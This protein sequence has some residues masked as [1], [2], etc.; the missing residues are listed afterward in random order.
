ML[1]KEGTIQLEQVQVLDQLKRYMDHLN[2]LRRINEGDDTSDS[3]GY[4]LSLV[5]IP[6]SINPGRNSQEG[7][8]AE[9]PMTATP[10]SAPTS[11]L[12]PPRLRHQRCHRPTSHPTRPVPESRPREQSEGVALHGSSVSRAHYDRAQR[13]LRKYRGRFSILRT[14]TISS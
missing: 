14:T 3:P 11:S 13:G 7:Y 10:S 5:R 6:V 8:G 2:E 4:S 12:T 9:I 1:G